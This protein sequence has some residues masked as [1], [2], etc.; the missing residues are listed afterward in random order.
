M[1][2]FT[3]SVLGRLTADGNNPIE[4]LHVRFERKRFPGL[5]SFSQSSVASCLS[6]NRI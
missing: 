2:A 4:T 6:Y 5:N 3:D 1:S